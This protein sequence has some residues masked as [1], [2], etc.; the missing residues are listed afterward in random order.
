MLMGGAEYSLVSELVLSMLKALGYPSTKTT[1]NLT[2]KFI[3]YNL[4]WIRQ[5][6]SLNAEKHRRHHLQTWPNRKHRASPRR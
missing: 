6:V 2:G 3:T 1:T 5:L 4:W